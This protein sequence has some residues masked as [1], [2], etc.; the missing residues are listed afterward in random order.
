MAMNGSFKPTLIY[1]TATGNG[2]TNDTAAIQAAIDALHA[3]G[4]G[5]L[6]FAVGTYKVTTLRY[7]DGIVFRGISPKSCIILGTAGSDIFAPHT[8]YAGSYT[9]QVIFEK[10]GISGG[11]N[12]INLGQVGA[13]NLVVRDCE[14]VT[15]SNAGFVVGA[16]MERCVFDHVQFIGGSYGFTLT[17]NGNSG[18]NYVDKTEF[19]SCRFTQQSV[20]GFFKDSARTCSTNTL[21]NCMFDNIGQDPFWMNGP[22]HDWIFLNLYFEAN[23]TSGPALADTTGGIA[24]G[25]RTLSVSSATNLAVSQQVTI[26]GAGVGGIDLVTTISAIAG[27]NVA[28]ANAGA[29]A[30]TTVTGIGVT[31][32]LYDCMHFASTGIK[33]RMNIL[34]GNIG[35]GTGTNDRIRYAI[36]TR[37]ATC[38]GQGGYNFHPIYDPDSSNTF[39]NWS[40]TIRTHS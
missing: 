13:T 8:S 28:L 2:V 26:Q 38:L 12:S 27:T 35:D 11:L 30:T 15:P 19:R 5:T 4:G 3:Q 18:S 9:D 20:N 31:N 37:G 34:G 6:D 24:S 25:S 40:G 29:A 1:S 22:A 7:Y 39:T 33:V 10:L 14:F 32:A 17:N 36:D 23:G 21:T 16:W